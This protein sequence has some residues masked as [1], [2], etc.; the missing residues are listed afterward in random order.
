[1]RS[2]FKLWAAVGTPARTEGDAHRAAAVGSGVAFHSGAPPSALCDCR[3][4]LSRANAAF[5]SSTMARGG[6]RVPLL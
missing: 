1:M 6:G 4:A 3:E 5:L 2:E